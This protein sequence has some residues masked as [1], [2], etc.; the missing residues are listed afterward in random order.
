MRESEGSA[1]GRRQ[2]LRWSLLGTVLVL[3]GGLVSGPVRAGSFE[4]S[5]HDFSGRDWTGG[6]A[7]AVCHTPHLRPGGRGGPLWSHAQS[8]AT[9]T[10]Y[11]S[12]T[13]DAV[14][15]AQPT[16][17]SKLCLS[18]HDGTVAVDS[19]GGRTGNYLLHG[20]PRLGT[21]LTNDHPISMIYDAALCERDGGLADPDTT[22][23]TIGS[24]AD[25]FTGTVSEVML[26][27][28]SVQCTTCHDVHNHYTAGTGKLL[29]IDNLGSAL[30]L[31]CHRK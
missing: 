8:S 25:T 27:G 26:V 10:M 23:V 30:C 6:D 20:F 21:D 24:G 2:V 16:G 15:S 29:R 4:G 28:G 3:V 13:F 11:S 9:Y 31:T 7:C 22:V 18:C 14:A 19:F 1:P 17:T 5:T 12:P